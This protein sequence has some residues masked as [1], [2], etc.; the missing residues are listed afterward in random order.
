MTRKD[1]ANEI[2]NSF[3]A[4][5]EIKTFKN[6]NECQDS[7]IHDIRYKISDFNLIYVLTVLVRWIATNINVNQIKKF[8]SLVV[9][10]YRETYVFNIIKT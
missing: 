4:I 2:L 7:S 5:W 1:F 3:T 6:T 9:L 8:L 10:E